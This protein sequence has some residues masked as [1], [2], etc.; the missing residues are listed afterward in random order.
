M[1]DGAQSS[2]SARNQ[3]AAAQSWRSALRSRRAGVAQ[4]KNLP[5]GGWFSFTFRRAPAA[6]NA[7]RLK[8]ENNHSGLL[9]GGIWII[10]Q[11]KMIDVYPQPEQLGNISS[12][13]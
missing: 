4:E 11:F 6:F 9:A 8:N 10:D 1:G 13:S 3:H 2:S 12:K 7:M 5:D